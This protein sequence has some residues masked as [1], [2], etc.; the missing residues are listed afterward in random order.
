MSAL[1]GP[2]HAGPRAFV[3][4]SPFRLAQAGPI[5]LQGCHPDFSRT[6]DALAGENCATVHGEEWGAGE[7]SGRGLRR[8]VGLSGMSPAPGN[9]PHRVDF[10]L[11]AAHPRF[12]A[13]PHTL[14]RPPNPGP[15]PLISMV[16]SFSFLRGNSNRTFSAG[17][18]DPTPRKGVTF[19]WVLKPF[20]LIRALLCL[21]VISLH[22]GKF[23]G[24]LS[25]VSPKLA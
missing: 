2:R 3:S 6:A 5:P 4:T 24:M 9:R 15:F 8:L 23:M 11:Q 20:A 21:V 10:F 25:F 22:A 13:L 19:L 7:L 14:Q 16:N 17:P 12:L 1:R 18:L